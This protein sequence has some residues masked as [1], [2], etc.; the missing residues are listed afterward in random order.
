MKYIIKLKLPSILALF[1]FVS[2]VGFGL[3]AH[4]YKK[5]S[6][7]GNGVTVNVK[8][9]QLAPGKQAE[10]KIRM[11]THSVELDQDLTAVVTLEDGQGNKYHP[12]TWDGSA[13][14]GHHRSGVLIFPKIE[15]SPGKVTLTIQK[16]GGIKR[17]FVWNVE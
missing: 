5:Q 12:L 15:K 11:N 13:P 10:F 8:P 3:N 7:R 4:A 2:I 1:V 17:I 16:V 14:G 9:N 6:N